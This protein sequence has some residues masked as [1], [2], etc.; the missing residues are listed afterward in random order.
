MNPLQRAVSCIFVASEM[1]SLLDELEFVQDLSTCS[2]DSSL[3][4]VKI[5]LR[6][7]IW[8][9]DQHLSLR[10]KSV[11]TNSDYAKHSE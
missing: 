8:V 9:C 11:D 4:F 1:W 2:G 3:V 6:C 7:V 5:R 10:G